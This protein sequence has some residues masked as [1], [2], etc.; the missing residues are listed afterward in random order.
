M[1]R[2]Y[3]YEINFYY[4]GR[5]TATYHSNTIRGLYRVIR[6]EYPVCEDGAVT[7]YEHFGYYEVNGNRS[8]VERVR[9]YCEGYAYKLYECGRYGDRVLIDTETY[10]D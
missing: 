6:K 1:K 8:E 4:D 5:L 2:K 9:V 10:P 7:Q 3:L